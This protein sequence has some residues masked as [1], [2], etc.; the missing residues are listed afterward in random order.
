MY[1]IDDTFNQA[2]TPGNE[3]GVYGASYTA[4]AGDY[5]NSG[6]V[7]VSEW[8]SFKDALYEYIRS[9]E[10]VE[11]DKYVDMPDLSTMETD[12][13]FN[14]VGFT[15]DNNITASWTGFSNDMYANSE[16]Y[17]V[18]DLVYSDSSDSLAVPKVLTYQGKFPLLDYG[19]TV[20]WVDLQYEDDTYYLRYI[21][22]TPI[23]A[24][25]GDS[26]SYI[27]GLP[28]QIWFNND[29]SINSVRT[30]IDIDTDSLV[31]NIVG[32][33]FDNS[34]PALTDLERINNGYSDIM[35]AG[36]Q[37]VTF[38]WS[39][40]FNDSNYYIQVRTTFKY[41]LNASDIW[42]QVTIDTSVPSGR[43]STLIDSGSFTYVFGDYVDLYY[44]QDNSIWTDDNLRKQGNILPIKDSL[45]IVCINEGSV[46]YGPWTTFT[47]K[48][49]IWETGTVTGTSN[50]DFIDEDNSGGNIPDTEENSKNFLQ[51]FDFNNVSGAWDAFISMFKNL[52]N[53]LGE[54]PALFAVVFSFLPYELRSMIYLS[55]ISVCVIGLIKVV[56]K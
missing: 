35:D 53:F 13:T 22:V 29:G 23:G 30:P 20:P 8:Y 16:S 27:K 52:T 42:E 46:T 32:G 19:F 37:S 24:L 17:A 50:S 34:I 45:R 41:K 26:T 44:Q 51:D 7:S 10:F 38:N 31:T 12:S 6:E 36:T 5:L 40:L 49:G 9:S 14:L 11:L 15:A 47:L 18:L 56:I 39:N 4:S 28:S 55:L 33:T 43:Y 48:N 54:F 1:N 2:H 3:A 25:I 21:R